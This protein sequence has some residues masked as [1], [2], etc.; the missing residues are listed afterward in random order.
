MDI[1]R[2]GRER[3]REREREGRQ[4]VGEGGR[5]GHGETTVIIFILQPCN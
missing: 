5:E 4:G 3:E 1:V 2:E